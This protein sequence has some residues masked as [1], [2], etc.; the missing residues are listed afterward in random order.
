MISMNFAD[1]GRLTTLVVLIGSILIGLSIAVGSAILP[2]TIA[3]MIIVIIFY[4]R[5]RV[6]EVMHDEIIYKM[7]QKAGKLAIYIATPSFAVIGLIIVALR[8]WLPPLLVDSG[9]F[10]SFTSI[11]LALIY[12]LCYIYYSNKHGSEW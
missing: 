7:T 5:T 3:T 1:F 10:M 6:T 4:L 9:Y 2:I 11:I 8:K 12:A